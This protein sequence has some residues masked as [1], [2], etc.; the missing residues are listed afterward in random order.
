MV[1]ATSY[2]SVS[3]V[4]LIRV[5]SLEAKP[6]GGKLLSSDFSISCTAGGNNVRHGLKAGSNSQRR[7]QIGYI[8]E[9]YRIQSDRS[10]PFQ[11][12]AQSVRLIKDVR[13]SCGNDQH[14]LLYGT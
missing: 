13:K 2:L 3:L 1:G 12:W 10:R 5:V 14:C 6:C 11:W 8:A 4:N 7:K 9:V